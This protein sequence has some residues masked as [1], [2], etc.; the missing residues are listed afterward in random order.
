MT[1]TGVG[2]EHAKWSPV[3]TAWYR[4]MPEV[5]LLQPVKDELAKELAGAG[6]DEDRGV[7]EGY[8]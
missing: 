7:L 2:E 3:A 6:E 4:F 8:R 5:V 1:C